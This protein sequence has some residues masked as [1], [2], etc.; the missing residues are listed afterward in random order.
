MNPSTD[1]AKNA[2]RM[3]ADQRSD[4]GTTVSTTRKARSSELEPGPPPSLWECGNRAS[5]FLARFP[6]AVGSVEK[7]RSYLRTLYG[8]RMDFSTLCT[9]RHFH[10]EYCGAFGLYQGWS[11]N[12]VAVR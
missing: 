12:L 5:L 9:A 4:M 10:S 3:P 6:S 11:K 2:S 7:S 8:R 1:G